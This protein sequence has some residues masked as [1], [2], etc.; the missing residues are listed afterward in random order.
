MHVTGRF[1]SSFNLTFCFFHRMKNNLQLDKRCSSINGCWYC[2]E[3]CHICMKLA[4]QAY[5]SIF[6]AEKLMFK[7]C[8]AECK[9]IVDKVS[10]F[11]TE[12]YPSYPLK[13]MT[14]VLASI[15]GC[16]ATVMSIRT[17]VQVN[18]CISM[19]RNSIT[20]GRPYATVQ[21]HTEEQNVF[22][23]VYLS[24][25]FSPTQPVDDFP[26]AFSFQILR[27]SNLLKEIFRM[28]LHPLDIFSIS[29]LL[30]YVTKA[31]FTLAKMFSISCSPYER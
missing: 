18:I 14:N 31:D 17:I 25:D 2:G 20:Y 21:L 9:A 19:Q 8:S 24:A 10:Q 28:S 4:N 3:R 22:F 13:Q 5:N 16:L 29:D 26:P 27:E 1:V 30:R 6:P 23:S 15:M 12:L 11:S 7:H